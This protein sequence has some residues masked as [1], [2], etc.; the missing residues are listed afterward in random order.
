MKPIKYPFK[1]IWLFLPCLNEEGNLKPIVKA[2]LNLKIPQLHIALIVDK[3]TDKTETIADQLKNQYP[4]K[5]AVLHRQPPASRALAGK[6]A[7]MFCLNKQADVIIEMDADFS[8]HPKYIP[9][10]LKEL[11]DPQVDVVLGSRFLPGGS[12]SDRSSFRTFIS[13]LSGIVFRIILGI[14]LTDMGSGFKTYKRKALQS[15]KPQ[16]LFS[17]KGLAISTESIFRVLKNGYQVKEIPIIFKD[18]RAGESKLSWKDFFEPVIISFK[19]VRHLGRY[20]G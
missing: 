11:T 7:F 3:S 1:N 20:H 9:Q 12:D 18:R 19:L 14:K 2:I 8:H 17:Q 5:I 10:M 4:Q 13:Q 16:Q 6:D 15:I